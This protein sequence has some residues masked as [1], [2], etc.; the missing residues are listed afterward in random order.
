M[1]CKLY[2][3]QGKLVKSVDIAKDGRLDLSDI[4]SGMYHFSIE[5]KY[6]KLSGNVLVVK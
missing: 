6:L 2:D 1:K 3:Y 4:A 5:N